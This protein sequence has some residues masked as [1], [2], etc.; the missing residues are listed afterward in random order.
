MSKGEE[1]KLNQR[2]MSKGI[3]YLGLLAVLGIFALRKKL[4]RGQQVELPRIQ[5]ERKSHLTVSDWVTFLTGEKYGL[6]STYFAFLSVMVALFGIL[7]ITGTTD[8]SRIIG[9]IML[10]G[11]LVYLIYFGAA[12]RLQKR[13]KLVDEIL[14][15]IICGDLTD[16]ENI[17]KQWMDGLKQ[18]K[19]KGKD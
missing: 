5:D 8:W 7:L 12:N 10:L 2:S 1:V 15:R 6:A 16:G 9:A 11:A 17:H 4:K 18:I 13:R 14:D 3:I 19:K